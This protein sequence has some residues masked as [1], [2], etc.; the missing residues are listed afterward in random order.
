MERQPYGK[1][2]FKNHDKEYPIRGN[3]FNYP[4]EV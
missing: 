2:T 4:E 3:D 1:K